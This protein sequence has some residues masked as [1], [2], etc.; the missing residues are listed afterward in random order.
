MSFMAFMKWK[1]LCKPKEVGRLGFR[2]FSDINMALLSKLTWMIASDKD[3]LWIRC[4]KAKYLKG[5]SI[6]ESKILEA[7]RMCGNIF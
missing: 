5:K 2:R 4:F 1:E 6:F 7:T 3:S